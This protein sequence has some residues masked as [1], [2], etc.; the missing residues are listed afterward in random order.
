MTEE[1]HALRKD[2]QLQPDKVDDTLERMSS[3]RMDSILQDFDSFKSYLKQR[4]EV[5]ENIGLNEEQLAVVTEKIADYLA[6]HA[7][8]KNREEKLLQELWK[9]GTQDQRH[10]LAHMLV[11]LVDQQ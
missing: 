2:G 7:E 1:N 8:P 3:D 9:V 4:L 11:R 10:H 5:A 6:E